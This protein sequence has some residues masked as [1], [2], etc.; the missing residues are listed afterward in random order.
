VRLAREAAP[1]VAIDYLT[2]PT[3]VSKRIGCIGETFDLSAV[4]LK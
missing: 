2:D 4:C 1:M 3:L